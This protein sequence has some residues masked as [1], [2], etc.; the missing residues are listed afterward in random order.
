MANT[1]R[2]TFYSIIRGACVIYQNPYITVYLPTISLCSLL[3]QVYWSF[4]TNTSYQ[5]VCHIVQYC[6]DTY[7][8]V[9]MKNHYSLLV[10]NIISRDLLFPFSLTTFPRLILFFRKFDVIVKLPKRE[11]NVVRHISGIRRLS[12]ITKAVTLA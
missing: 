5:P 11:H 6:N 4:F 3:V 9:Q 12:Y 1:S 8:T 10:R 2:P 7:S